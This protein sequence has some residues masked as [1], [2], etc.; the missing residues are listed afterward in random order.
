[1]D[2]ALVS[3]IGDLVKTG[4]L[5]TMLSVFIVMYVRKDKSL[6]DVTDKFTDRLIALSRETVVAVEKTSD[7]AAQLAR[8]QEVIERQRSEVDL[9]RE[10][11]SRDTPQAFRPPTRSRP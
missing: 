5:G 11:A 4:V 7:I 1:M 9:A 3:L 10:H 8:Q 2:Q 6:Q